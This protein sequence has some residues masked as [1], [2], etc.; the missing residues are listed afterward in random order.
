MIFRQFRAADKQLS[1]LFADPVTRQAA[2]LDPHFDLESDY[3][4]VIDH[5]DLKLAFVIETHAHESHLSAAPILCAETGAAWGASPRVECDGAMRAVR[6]GECIYIGEE[7]FGALET[8]GHSP[9]SLCFRWR[10]LVFT[11]HTLLAGRAGP[12][13]RPD[14]DAGQLYDSIVE[15]LFDLPGNT[16]VLPGYDAGPEETTIGWERHNNAE[17]GRGAKRPSFIECKNAEQPAASW[18]I[19]PPLTGGRP[20]NL[21]R[22]F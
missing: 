4:A 7:C 16:R 5:L 6:G 17:L 9:C 22:Y 15:T 11:G 18:A 12:C 3:L 13:N 20:A 19:R 21:Y 2:L 1:Y 14:S 10:D 8:P